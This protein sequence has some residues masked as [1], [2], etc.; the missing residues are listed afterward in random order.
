MVEHFLKSLHYYT[1][2]K[3]VNSTKH[4]SSVEANN[5]SFNH[6]ISHLSS[7]LLVPTT[8]IKQ[9]LS[10]SIQTMP[11]ILKYWININIILP[12][13]PVFFHEAFIFRFPNQ[14]L[15]HISVLSHM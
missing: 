3:I 15:L 6:E 5:L 10:I 4:I 11:H 12:S 1:T 2:S 9:P 13:T 14:N 8:T 7:Y